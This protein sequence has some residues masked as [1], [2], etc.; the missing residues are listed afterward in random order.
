MPDTVKRWIRVGPVDRPRKLQIDAVVI[1]GIPGI[2][3]HKS[4]KFPKERGWV[5]TH[6]AS[7][8]R[9]SGYAAKKFSDAVEIVKNFT[10]E[11]DIDWTVSAKQLMK[12]PGI[13][14]AFTEMVKEICG[15]A[16]YKHKGPIVPTSKL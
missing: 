14:G 13:D 9:L 3:L 2:F 5:F 16:I 8:L 4:H 6:R 7:G 12:T 15:D 11:Y 1:P 10:E